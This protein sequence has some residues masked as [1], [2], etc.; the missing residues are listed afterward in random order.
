[1]I[2]FQKVYKI[3][4]PR[5][6]LIYFN[7]FKKFIK[8]PERIF[9]LKA[10]K[11]CVRANHAHKICSQFLFSINGNIEIIIDNGK[12]IKTHKLK[13]GS[14]LEIKPL[15]WLRVNL[16]KNQILAVICNKP[17]LENEYIRDYKK[18]LKLVRFN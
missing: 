10:K 4:D 3:T 16:K 6:E 11:N 14:I 1:M 15:N 5:C 13:S 2:K 9:F 7:K 17:Y 12:K 8:T 18:F